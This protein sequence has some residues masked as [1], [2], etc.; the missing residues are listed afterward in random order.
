MCV[1]TNS[2]EIGVE[3]IANGI[4]HFK[5]KKN[6]IDGSLS[7]SSCIHD[8]CVQWRWKITQ[9]VGNGVN[10]MA[11]LKNRVSEKMWHKRAYS[12]SDISMGP[13]F[14]PYL[15][16]FHW[17][18]MCS[19]RLLD[20]NLSISLIRFGGRIIIVYRVC[21]FVCV[22]VCSCSWSCHFFLYLCFSVFSAF[23]QR[24]GIFF[25]FARFYVL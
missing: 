17:F 4:E 22:C 9:L 16:W 24:F 14:S 23:F 1:Q 13:S 21:F 18:I 15:T 20:F 2:V 6:Q 12:L 19:T 7:V 8:R 5:K 11:E 10:A 3:M 25:F